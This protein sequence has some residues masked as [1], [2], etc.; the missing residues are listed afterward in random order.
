MAKNIT[1]NDLAVM[2][3]N[4]FVNIEKSTDKKIGDLAEKMEKGFVRIEK[5]TDKKIGDLAI[6]VQKGFEQTASKVDLENLKTEMNQRFDRV[7]NVLI[8]KHDERITYL[9]QRVRELGAALEA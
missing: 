8:A 5:S 7:E 4:G 1:T 9:E 6:M 2:M 3:E